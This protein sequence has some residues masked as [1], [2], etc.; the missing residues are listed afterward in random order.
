[1]ACEFINT[2]VC[3]VSEGIANLRA[4]LGKDAEGFTPKD[5]R[6]LVC[7]VENDGVREKDCPTFQ[8]R[9]GLS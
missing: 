7:K 9:K 2:R 5:L 4:R 6:E 8:T 3:P 1:M